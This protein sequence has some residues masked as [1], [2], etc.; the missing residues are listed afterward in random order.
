MRS[1]CRCIAATVCKGNH[2]VYKRAFRRWDALPVYYGMEGFSSLLFQLAVTTYVLY[3]ASAVGLDALQIVL[4]GTV[5]ESAIF[6]FEIPTGVVADVYS[7][8]L[9]IILGIGI[10]GIS[11]VME[12]AFPVFSL[13]LLAEIISGIGFTFTSGAIEAW[14]TDEIG[15]ERSG[16]VFVRAAQIKTITGMIG[17]M[18]GA[19]LASLQLNLPFLL[20]GT[21]LIVLALV[22]AFVMPEQGFHTTA[23]RS[24]WRSLFATF[25]A[26][27][28]LVRGRRILLLILAVAFIYAFHSEGFDHLWQ[29]HLL[30]NF[31]LPA[32][33][34]LNPIV[35]FGVIGL[36][37]SL[38]SIALNE[39]VRRRV[40][41]NDA[42]KT[43]RALMLIY[44]VVSV[45]ILVFSISGDFKTAI[46]AYWLV[47]ALR[48]SAEPVGKAWLNQQI[49]PGIRATLFSMQGQVSALGE[50]VGGPP[51]GAIG[52][53]FSVRAALA[54]SGLI[55]ALTLPF[56]AAAFVVLAAQTVRK[57]RR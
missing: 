6:L 7:R 49:E 10:I 11:W 48:N 3:Y 12:G 37:S 13:L 5:F 16:K 25:R 28:R 44:G 41:L 23:Q 39:I 38:L 31:T 32:L 20:A 14:I 57:G 17:I 46:A 2:M 56:F 19:L 53:L 55:L 30:D 50:I 52:K 22:L 35:W 47:S 42:A 33:G 24:T 51:V 40:N 29:K 4:V 1:L 15:V 43:A 34:T 18:S 21:L 36:G 9:S 54:A 8:R 27:L 26:G 45:G